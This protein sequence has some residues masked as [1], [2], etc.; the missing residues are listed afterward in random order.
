MSVVKSIAWI[1]VIL[2]GLVIILFY[3]LQARLIFYPGRLDP[4][5][6]FRLEPTGEE[7]VLKTADG[8]QIHGLFFAN[9]SAD[10]I[11]YFHGNAGDLGGWQF[12]A[13]DFIALGYNF[14]IID[15]RGYGK[16]SGK[17]TEKGLY[18]DADA[19]FDFLLQKGFSP[20]DILVYG[21]SVGSGVA[22]DLAA[23]QSCKGLI[24][25]S[26]FSSLSILANEKL[27]LFFPS[28]Y[29]RFRF[30]NIGKMNRVKCPV[31]F[32]HGSDDTLIPPSHSAKLYEKFTGKKKMIIVD[33]GSHNDLHAF[34]QY[35]QFLKDELATYFR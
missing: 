11:L 19:A 32:L 3:T 26:P 10:V 18:L 25:E 21:R 28:L 16:S 12:V 29:L 8:E 17:I 33:H 23:K 30:D 2:Y 22:V 15:Y 6:K 5:F 9:Q 35:D 34:R 24:L 4:D 14:L 20:G 13:D 7:V 1:F 27:P 31:I